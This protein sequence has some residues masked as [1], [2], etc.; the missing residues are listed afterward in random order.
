MTLDL[1]KRAEKGSQL[2]STEHDA[3][4]T[5]IENEVNGKTDIGHEHSN[6]IFVEEGAN[7]TALAAAFEDAADN[8]KKI[9]FA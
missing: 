5:A 7:D 1:L 3:N 4:F 9:V 2:N 8:G 6:I